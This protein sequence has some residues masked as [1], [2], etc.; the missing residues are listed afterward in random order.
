MVAEGAC[1]D[2]DLPEGQC[3]DNDL[4]RGRRVSDGMRGEVF[5]RSRGSLLV[6][7][8]HDFSLLELPSSALVKVTLLEVYAG[9]I[10]REV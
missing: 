9:S 1:Q 8:P 10:T 7:F 4:F 3:Q 6:K 2:D 5:G